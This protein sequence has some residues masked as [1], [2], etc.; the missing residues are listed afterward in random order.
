M[1]LDS[2]DFYSEMAQVALI[3]LSHIHNLAGTEPV[4]QF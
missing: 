4:V 2:L 3:Q 1:E